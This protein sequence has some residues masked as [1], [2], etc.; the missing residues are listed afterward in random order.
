ME[1][2]I[3]MDVVSREEIESLRP[4]RTFLDSRCR[5]SQDT[6][7]TYLTGLVYLDNF[8]R[9]AYGHTVETVLQ[10]LTRGDINV[11]E[12]LDSF[13]TEQLKTVS[14]KSATLRLAVVKSYLEFQDVDIVA[15]KFKKR[16]TLPKV[17]REDE[18]PVD[19]AD[20]RKIL[21]KLANRRLKAYLL[22]LASG[23]MR[24]REGLAIRMRDI[25]FSVSP[26]KVHIRKE[27]AKTRVTR[28]V[29]IS[30]EAAQYLREWIDW[31][32]RNKETPAKPEEELVFGVGQSTDPSEL[33]KAI[34]HEFSKYLELAGFTERKDD[35]NRH[36][37][38][39]H[40]FRRFVDSTITDLAGK[41]YAEWFLGHSKSPY[42]TKKEPER[43]EIYAT[44]CMKY[45]TFLDYSLLEAAGHS[46]EASIQEKA[47]EIQ[48][49]KEQ[50]AKMEESQLKITEL[51]E[52][53]KIA[54]SSDGKVGK[55]RTMLDEKR[56]VTIGYMD[57]NNQSVEM[58]VPLDGFEIDEAGVDVV[59]SNLPK[60]RA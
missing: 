42:Y 25:D 46:T 38:T 22:V 37:V 9:G 48:A 56:R 28:D 36:K 45:L 16:V 30:D 39:I 44:K 6:R 20:I 57:D 32:Y 43:R 5:N 33:Y 54:K 11:Y 41:D 60:R 23:G 50:M 3:S 24:A 7:R 19:A 47:K 26:T 21:L 53:M 27:Y 35:S 17:H 59:T 29:Y 58:K 31:K 2:Q 34:Q 52:V 1:Q 49:L 40:S 8:M 12:L 14:D 51:L 55:D 13:V 4:V 10:S 15:S 18:Q